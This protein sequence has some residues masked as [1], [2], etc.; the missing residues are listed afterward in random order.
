MDGQKD[1]GRERQMDGQCFLSSRTGN[2]EVVMALLTPLNVNCHAGDGRKV[3]Q[4]RERGEREGRGKKA[5][6]GER[7]G[8]TNW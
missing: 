3:S 7:K 1:R 5:P 4:E 8:R 6:V 2:E